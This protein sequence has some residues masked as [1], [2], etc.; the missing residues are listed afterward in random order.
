MDI[1]FT[2][3]LDKDNVV[4]YVLRHKEEYQG[5]MPWEKI[6]ILRTMF[7]EES[8]RKRKIEEMYVE[9]HLT[10]NYFNDFC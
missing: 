1:K 2:H 9:D 10:K 7:V 6:Q 3:K 4:P 8:D 5:E